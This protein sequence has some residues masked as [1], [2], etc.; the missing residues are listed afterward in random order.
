MAG[1]LIL[2][3]SVINVIPSNH[4]Q[5]F[6]DPKSVIEEFDKTRNSLLW[7]HDRGAH[8]LHHFSKDLAMKSKDSGGLGLKDLHYINTAFLAKKFWNLLL[9]KENLLFQVL[10]GKYLKSGEPLLQASFKQG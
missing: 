5:C 8:K 1:R 7:N 10:Q 4:F 2:L 3:T 6:L 9:D